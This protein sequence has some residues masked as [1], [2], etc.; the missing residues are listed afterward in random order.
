MDELNRIS[1][2][3]FRSMPK[4]PLAVVID[5]IRSGINVGSFFRTADAF[6]LEHLHLCGITAQPPHREILKSAIG[7]TSS[8]AWSAHHDVGDCI[9]FLKDQDYLIA[10][11]EQ[12]NESIYLSD[13]I[14]PEKKKVALVFGNEVDGITE[15]ILPLIDTCLEIP[16]Y[17]T[18]HSLNVAVCAGIVIWHISQ[19]MRARSIK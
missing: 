12:T 15:S 11:V 5:N 6:A 17:G 8:V 16:Q 3:Q 19:Q 9:R 14:V 7:A 1:T 2:E 10:A 4:L 18:K 13:F